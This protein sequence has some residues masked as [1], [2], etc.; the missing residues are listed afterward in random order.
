MNREITRNIR[1]GFF[2]MAGLLLL[3]SSLYMIGSK[4]NLF[5]STIKVNVTFHN[6]NGLI[7]GN[8]VRF[9]GIDVG[10]VSKIQIESDSILH[11][12]L[13]ID[14][15]VSKFISSTSIASIGTDGL[16]GNKLVNIT[17]G[18]GIGKSLEEGVSLSSIKPIDMDETLRTLTKTNDNL[19]YITSDIKSI[20]QRISAKNTLWS[21]L[22][23]SSIAKNLKQ[24]ISNITATTQNASN[25]S[26]TLNATMTDIKNGKGTLGKLLT[27]TSLSS[28]I[29]QTVSNFN[30]SSRN[31]V[32]ITNDLNTIVNNTKKGEGSVGSLLK[33]TTTVHNLNSAI[34]SLDKG[35]QG[36]NENME[37][38]KHNFFFRKYFRNK[39][40]AAKKK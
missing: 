20:A 30:Q 40:K 18:T 15:N 25:F 34:I 24:S 13:V 3:I 33:D 36:F 9:N 14:K 22:M 4:R 28:S 19:Q 29:D 31:A 2:V 32:T 35:A 27:D 16:M 37:A 39:E 10:T 1:L 11:V 17:P 21:I 5:N 7:E 26:K 12:E 38:M 8:N 23:D 6:V